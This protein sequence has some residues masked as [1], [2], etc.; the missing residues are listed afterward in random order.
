MTTAAQLAALQSQLD[1]IRASVVR[2]DAVAE[3]APPPPPP[4][5]PPPAPPPPPPAP[6]PA[7]TG[8]V[9]YFAATGNNANPG[10]MASPK[11]DLG[12]VNHNSLPGG[13]SLRFKAG[14]AWTFGNRVGL[15]NLNASAANPLTFE[16]YGEGPRPVF[17]WPTSPIGFATGDNFF[18][19]RE[20]GGYVIRGL[21]LR[22]PNNQEATTAIN[23]MRRARDIIIE[24]C[25][26]TRWYTGIDNNAHN[27]T[28]VTIRNNRIWQLRGHGILGHIYGGLIEGND[29]SDDTV[30]QSHWVHRIYLGGGA[31]NTVRG[32]RFV[33]AQPCAGGTVTFHGLQ[34]GIVVENNTLHYGPGGSGWLISLEPYVGMGQQGFQDAIIR[35]NSVQNGGP[36][37]IHVKC[38]P[39]A[40]IESN[41]IRQTVVSSVSA[42]A[43]QN[44]PE[45]LTNLN[46]P[47]IVR[48]N[49]AIGPAGC[50][51]GFSA[52]P[53]STVSNNVTVV[54]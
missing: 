5:P 1:A 32:N 14:D 53:G 54:E 41:T 34:P 19:E 39:G 17:E 45:V 40:L 42:I 35:G 9:L 2:I 46:G 33:T 29:F 22:G 37:V 3:P 6:P 52:P 23:A 47:G 15:I 8:A 30:Q 31:N 27:V 11:R 38:A 43:Y 12:G 25:E 51:F 20:H 10:T 18:D 49:T 50:S 21:H 48:N 13:S 44:D 24:G 36:D 28:N 26:I 7:P 4:A 16:S